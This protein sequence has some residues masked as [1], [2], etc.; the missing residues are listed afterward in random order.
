MI[1]RAPSQH[2]RSVLSHDDSQLAAAVQYSLRQQNSMEAEIDSPTLRRPVD[3]LPLRRR[4]A[5]QGLLQAA[6]SHTQCY[7][8]VGLPAEPA[9]RPIVMVGHQPQLFHPGVWFKNF[10][11]HRLSHEL[12]AIAVHVIIDNDL[13]RRPVISVPAGKPSDP[14]LQQVAF[15]E[16][17]RRLPYESRP[18]I[19]SDIFE[20]VAD[21]VR[22]AMDQY[23]FEPLISQIWPDA[24][25]AARETSRIGLATA[26]ARH[27]LEQRWGL[28]SLEVPLS[29]LC[30]QA[31]FHEFFLDL[32]MRLEEVHHSYN[33][34][35]SAF[36]R[37]HGIRSKMHPVP[38]LR[39]QDDWWELPFWCSTEQDPDRRPLYV[40]RYG[41]SFRLSNLA[42]ST[43]ELSGVGDDVPS[44][45]V[46]LME[47][48]ELGLQLRPRAL[49]TT[50]FLRR[51][52]CDLFIHGI[53]GGSYDRLT[54]RWMRRLYGV[55]PP[56][57]LTTT[58]T[59]RLPGNENP[60]AVEEM[61][62]IQLAF[63]E[64]EFH[65]ENFV[66]GTPDLALEAF[67]ERK[68][69]CLKQIPIDKS[70]GPAWHRRLMEINHQIRSAMEPARLQLEQRRL[71]LDR[72]F[73]RES[74]L[75]SREFAYCL[76][77]EAELRLTMCSMMSAQNSHI[78]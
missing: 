66:S 50:L 10:V 4:L 34:E 67:L 39:R 75:S 42:L 57:Y 54:D 22:T 46:R 13:C 1:P 8:N 32:M 60:T 58:A 74:W 9:E 53:G 64:F 63:R 28:R 31:S 19:D 61:T 76:F 3:R 59:V 40:Q 33:D 5:R 15:D 2:G 36:R 68:R 65:P 37:L 24:V 69:V 12:G 73:R 45:L 55:D 51:Y 7:R 62:A 48:Q 18:V 56:I 70:E 43:W 35:L 27:Q 44:G 52:L 6:V 11:M 41:E 29:N 25:A 38:S 17:T 16:D 20:T 21:R 30:R 26:R 14:Y 77:P 72:T 49:T 47:L 71:E 23:P 78:R